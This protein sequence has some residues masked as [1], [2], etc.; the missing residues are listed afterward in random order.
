MNL[1]KILELFNLKQHVSTPTHKLGNTIDSVIS[2]QKYG[3]LLDLHTSNFLPD[4]CTIEWLYKIN[5]LD[6]VKTRLFVRNL[7][8]INQD[9]FARDLALAINENIHDGQSLQELYD[10]FISVLCKVD[11]GILYVLYS[12]CIIV[13]IS[14]IFFIFLYFV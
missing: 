7:R 2:I 12:I 9:E 10:G 1:N 3:G 11:G 14:H 13:C 4:H 5:R 8:K 6:T